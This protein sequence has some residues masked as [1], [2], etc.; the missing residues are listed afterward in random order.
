MLLSGMKALTG[1]RKKKNRKVIN[2][3]LRSPQPI[4]TYELKDVNNSITELT[5]STEISMVKNSTCAAG[6]MILFIMFIFI[7]ISS[8]VKGHALNF[9]LIVN[10]RKLIKQE[11]SHGQAEV[12][13]FYA[14]I[15]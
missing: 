11:F 8:G 7:E 1:F 5:I 3:R 4:K 9:G 14:F 6:C 13:C 2:V 15:F 12:T 10:R